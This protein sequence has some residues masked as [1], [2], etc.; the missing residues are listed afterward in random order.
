MRWPILLAC[1]AVLAPS[2]A[3]A[4]AEMLGKGTMQVGG[5]ASFNV[6]QV[7]SVAVTRGYRFSVSP[8]FGY[9]VI[10]RLELRVGAGFDVPFGSLHQDA[11]KT[12]F[13]DGGARYYLDAGHG[14]YPYLGAAAGPLLAILDTGETST[15]IAFSIPFGLLYAFNRHVALDVGARVDYSRVL[16]NGS[17]STLTVPIG[18][19]GVQA[20]FD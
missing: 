18:Y 5:S 4:D 15:S 17:G 9:F 19:F 6:E 20:F 2:L 16:T 8:G 11:T 13:V 1:A 10:D 7:S 3:R 12:V 14:L